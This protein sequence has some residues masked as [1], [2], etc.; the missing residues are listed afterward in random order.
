MTTEFSAEEAQARLPELLDRVESGEEIVITRFG[1]PS[2]ALHRAGSRRSPEMVSAGV[3]TAAWLA[4]IAGG[5]AADAGFDVGTDYAP[6]D[7]GFSG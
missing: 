6:G 1:A 4:P 2:V 5:A 7:V 3:L